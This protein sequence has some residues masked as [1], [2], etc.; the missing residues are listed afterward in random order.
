MEFKTYLRILVNRWWIILPSFLITFIATVVFTFTQPVVYQATATYVVR[1]GVIFQD[2]RSFVSALDTLSRRVEIASTYA[3]V[4]NSRVIKNLAA[5]ALG[6]SPEHRRSLSVDSR[7]IAGTNILEIIVEGNDPVLVRDF[8]NAV[9]AQTVAYV[10]KL[11]ETYELELLDQAALP[12]SPVKPDKVLNLTLGGLFGLILGVGLALFAEYLRSGS[13][14]SPVHRE[15]EAVAYTPTQLTFKLQQELAL[16]QAQFETTRRRFEQTQATL[17]GAGRA[18]AVDSSARAPEEQATAGRIQ[19][20][21]AEPETSEWEAAF[22]ELMQQL[23]I[24]QARLAELQRLT[25]N[26]RTGPGA[27][28]APSNGRRAH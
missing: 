27:A 16:L 8:T 19:P 2:D 7:L 9:G 4:T 18:G 20:G 22:T 15:P 3:E 24:T 11:Y 17:P 10:Q 14:P 25:R 1:V 23:H 12:R 28:G 21:A 26:Y 6:L 13:A 5:D